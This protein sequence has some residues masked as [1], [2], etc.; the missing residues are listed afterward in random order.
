MCEISNGK[1]SSCYYWSGGDFISGRNGSEFWLSLC[2]GRPGI[3]L[4]ETVDRTK[5]RFQKAAE[6]RGYN[7]GD[8]FDEK[9]AMLLDRFA[10][11]GLIAAR[12][13]IADADIEWTHDL[14]ERT[15]IVTGS[16]VGGQTTEDEALP[17]YINASAHASI[18]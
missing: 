12:E 15:G 10:Q 17:I 16:C 6:V 4:I 7:S 8:Y 2:E 18:L 13:A 14:R 1:T 11:F 3:G 9:R 5:L